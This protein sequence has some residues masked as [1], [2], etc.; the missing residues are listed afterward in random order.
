[1]SIGKMSWTR[2]PRLSLALTVH[3]SLD[4][5]PRYEP[6]GDRGGDFCA[7]D[8]P[9]DVEGG[10]DVEVEESSVW[11]ERRGGL[12][13]RAGPPHQ[14]SLKAGEVTINTSTTNICYSLVDVFV[15][16]LGQLEPDPH[17]LPAPVALL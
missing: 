4:T 15:E 10:R 17:L 8:W 16:S 7:L 6:A 13:L 11:E 3:V 1:M 9:E 14:V 5:S 2:P 12:V